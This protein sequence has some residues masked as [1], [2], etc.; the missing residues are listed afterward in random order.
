LQPKCLA[1]ASTSQYQQAF[2]VEDV[3]GVNISE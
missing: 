1:P 2:D 3:G